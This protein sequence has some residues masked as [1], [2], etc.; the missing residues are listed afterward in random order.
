MSEVH[1][2]FEQFCNKPKDTQIIESKLFGKAY[3]MEE[4]IS[5]LKA[6][7]DKLGDYVEHRGY[8][9]L[10]SKNVFEC[11]CGLDELLKDDND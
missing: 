11:H 1:E 3:R 5:I 8:K 2:L 10:Y 9:C 4:Q 6:K 7:I